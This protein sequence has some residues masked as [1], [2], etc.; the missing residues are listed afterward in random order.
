MIYQADVFRADD[1]AHSFTLAFGAARSSTVGRCAPRDG[2]SPW[3][4]RA[5]VRSLLT[6]LA[7]PLTG[8]YGSN[9]GPPF[10]RTHARIEMRAHRG[11]FPAMLVDR[12]SALPFAGDV[13]I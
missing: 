4:R 7:L 6:R 13:M 1:E 8:V 3:G 5:R 11:P 10:A 2:Q 12:P 9:H